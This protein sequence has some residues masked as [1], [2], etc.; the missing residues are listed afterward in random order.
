MEDYFYSVEI[1]FYSDPCKYWLKTL[2]RESNCS[3]GCYTVYYTVSKAEYCILYN[4]RSYV[5][6]LLTLDN[7]NLSLF[8]TCFLYWNQDIVTY[9]SFYRL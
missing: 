1:L 9:I 4:A 8:T 5:Q 2:H 6:L 7:S 3:M